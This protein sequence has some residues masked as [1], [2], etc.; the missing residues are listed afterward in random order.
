MKN[1]HFEAGK[2]PQSREVQ[3]QRIQRVIRQELTECQ[4]DTLLSHYFQGQTISQIAALRGVHKR[5]VSR[6]LRR[7]EANLRRYLKY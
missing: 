2:Q 7:A 4:R 6:T 5:T 3:L 1:T